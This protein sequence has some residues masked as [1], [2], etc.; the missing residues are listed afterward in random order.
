VH[1][2]KVFR[3]RKTARCSKWQTLLVDRILEAKDIAAIFSEALS[4]PPVAIEV[5][6]DYA[7]AALSPVRAVLVL[8]SVAAGE[9]PMLISSLAHDAT[10]E[11]IDGGV[12][13]DVLCRRLKCRCVVPVLDLDP[14][15]ACL[16]ERPGEREYVSINPQAEGRTPPEFNID[17]HKSIVPPS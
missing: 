6:D 12:V 11:T 4:I 14:F 8:R 16:I 1:R 9:F 3:T 10:L 5:V 13:G 7:D 15:S 17:R 2:E